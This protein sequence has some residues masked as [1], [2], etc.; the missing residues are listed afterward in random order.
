MPQCVG[1]QECSLLQSLQGAEYSAT[2][3]T[4][5]WWVECVG[6]ATRTATLMGFPKRSRQN[7][8]SRK[9]ALTSPNHLSDHSANTPPAPSPLPSMRQARFSPD[10]ALLTYLAATSSKDKRSSLFAMDM[11]TLVSHNQTGP[12]LTCSVG[13]DARTTARHNNRSR[14]FLCV[15]WL[16]VTRRRTCRWK[17]SCVVSVSACEPL[18]LLP[19]FGTHKPHKLGPR[20]RLPSPARATST[21][22]VSSTTIPHPAAPARLAVCPRQANCRRQCRH[23]HAAAV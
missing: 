15:L 16:M 9:L 7:G 18:A 19:T 23:S 6:V 21:S 8:T 10:G 13:A 20:V 11:K 12:K 1:A 3:Q 22:Q 14:V 5:P 4:A 2:V 17:K